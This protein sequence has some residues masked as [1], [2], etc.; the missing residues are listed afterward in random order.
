MEAAA[1]S[2][3]HSLGFSRTLKPEIPKVFLSSNVF[4]SSSLRSL[5]LPSKNLRHQRFVSWSLPSERV[6]TASHQL[7]VLLEV[8]GVLL[9][10]YRSGNREAFNIAFQK[11]G[12]DCANWTEPIYLD[13][14]RKAGGDEER[15]LKL[16]FNR[17]GWPTSLPTSEK[18]NFM[19]SVLREK[20][21]A[22]DEYVMTKPLPL[23]PGTENFID[24]ALNEGI[25]VI[26]LTAYS[27]NGDKMARSVVEKLGNE[28]TSKLKIVGEEEMEKS[29]YGQL[30]FGKGVSSS[31]D[32][33][34]A[35]EASKAA[36]VEKQRIAKEVA[37]I[38]K[39]SVDI[40]TSSNERLKRIVVTLRAGAEYAGVPVQNC[41]LV[42]GSQSGVLAAEQIGMRSV[43]LRSSFTARAEFPS[44]NAVLDGFGGADL[45]V[46][47][48]RNLL[49]F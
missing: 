47:R 9:D 31:L 34:L 25:P 24:D 22:L 6:G 12:L 41:V 43:V 49:M 42:A 38:L 28:R 4:L 48:L 32:E 30:I 1:C 40:D 2:T 33:E 13:L 16:F 20:R 3:L 8:E 23:R 5:S 29:L 11:L 17:I 10:V 37:S 19:K 15:M 44:A 27:R 46:L 26:V 14:A 35:R 45:T 36:S 7:A 18:E 39:L 21:K